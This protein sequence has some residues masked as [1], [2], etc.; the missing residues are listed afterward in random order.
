MSALLP[1]VVLSAT[2]VALF[3]VVL[4][5]LLLG[6]VLASRTRPQPQQLVFAVVLLIPTV[7]I[8]SVFLSW[9]A[10]E[11]LRRYDVPVPE[12]TGI[13]LVVAAV[14]GLMAPLRLPG[15]SG[16][17]WLKPLLGFASGI[18]VPMSIIWSSEAGLHWLAAAGIGLLV[19]VVLVVFFRLIAK[20]LAD[21]RT[22]KQVR[23]SVRRFQGQLVDVTD[24]A[25]SLSS[26]RGTADRIVL[27]YSGEADGKPVG[28]ALMLKRDMDWVPKARENE[29]AVFEL[30]KGLNGQPT[31]AVLAQK[32]IGTPAT[33]T[34]RIPGTTILS[35]R[36]TV[37]D[38]LSWVEFIGKLEL[39]DADGLLKRQQPAD[40]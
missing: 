1:V 26:A 39:T 32:Q 21:R 8:G 23:T 20:P 24:A 38:S 12:L 18:L 11:W 17:F 34:M 15:G 5:L 33:L 9:W 2:L 40:D 25:W 36:E 31:E 4:P 10:V 27:T 28:A 30:A 22:A 16:P 35:I 19:L 37:A 29:S 13:A 6:P 7:A 3:G 14:V